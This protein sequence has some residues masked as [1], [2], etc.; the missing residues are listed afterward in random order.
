MAKEK[1]VE[2]PAASAAKKAAPVKAAEKK[3]AP[4]EKKTA[5]VEKK[6]AP[7]TKKVEVAAEVKAAPAEK[8]SA[9][10]TGKYKIIVNSFGDLFQF[11]LFAN[12]GQ[13]L[14]ESR[15]YASKKSCADG[16]ETFK[17]NIQDPAT[18]V[19]VDM[20]KNKHYKYIIKNRNSIYVGESYGNQAQAESSA[21]SVKRFALVSPIVE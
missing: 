17:K 20:D 1:K 8:K 14:Y 21:A 19:R 4:V 3:S 18:T 10:V 5:P 7:A 15:E 16:I 6:A 2:A 12:N 9:G 13:L 11:Q